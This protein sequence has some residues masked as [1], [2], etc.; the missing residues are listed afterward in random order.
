MSSGNPYTR[1]A[2]EAAINCKQRS[3]YSM[4][5]RLDHGPEAGRE[6]TSSFLKDGDGINAALKK[7]VRERMMSQDFAQSSLSG[8]YQAGKFWTN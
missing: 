3:A 7:T 1:A 8:K 6:A 5:M 2:A 4:A